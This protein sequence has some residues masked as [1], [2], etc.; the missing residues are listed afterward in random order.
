MS[1]KKYFT[2]APQI[3]SRMLSNKSTIILLLSIKYLW[4]M[5]LIVFITKTCNINSIQFQGHLF[6]IA[7]ICK[8]QMRKLIVWLAKLFHKIHKHDIRCIDVYNKISCESHTV[9]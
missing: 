5:K 7:L 2:L 9:A 3:W 8:G 4:I 6:N 1:M